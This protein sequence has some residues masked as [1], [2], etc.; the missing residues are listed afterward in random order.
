MRLL[1]VALATM[2]NQA[3]LQYSVRFRILPCLL[4]NY[5]IALRPYSLQTPVAS[6]A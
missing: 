1:I 2:V 3:A 5:P 4:P 6:R